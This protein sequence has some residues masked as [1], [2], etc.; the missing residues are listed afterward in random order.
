[1]NQPNF[2]LTV[3]EAIEQVPE[4]RRLYEQDERYSQLLDYAIALEGLSRHTGV[5]AAGVVIAPGPVSDYVPVCTQTSKGSGSA[6]DE[7][8]VVSQYDMNCL[9]KAGMLKMDFLG[10]TTL[11]VIHDALTMIAERRGESID[12][13]AI[14]L[15]DPEVYRMLRAGRTVGV[16]QFESPLAT[17]MLRG[18]RCDRF[19]DL[20]ASNALMRPGPLDAG[21]H[22]VYQ[23]RKKGEEPVA[24]AL[25]EL[26]AIL[27]PTYGVITYQEQ[28]MRIAQQLAGISL[29]EADV[30]RKAVGKKDAELIRQELDKFIEKSVARGYDRKVIRELA[31]QIET[32]GRYGFNKSHSVAYSIISYHT[33]WLKAHFA[34]EFMAALLSSSIGD[35]DN[36]VKYIA[37]A[38]ELGLEVLAPDVNES[39]YKFTVV[40][41][42]RLRFGLGA[43]RNVGHS[44]IDSILAARGERPFTDL[45]DLCERVDLRLCNRR[46]FEALITSGALDSFGVERSRMWAALDSA[47]QEA[48][49]RQAEKESGQASLFG[50]MTVQTPQAESTGTVHQPRYPNVPAWSESER[51]SKEKEILGFYISG[52]PLE[53]YRL[54]CELFATHTVSQLGTWTADPVALGVVITAVKR[55]ISKRSGSEFAR[56]TVEDFSGSAEV[57]IFPE[58]WAAIAD[59]VRTDIPVL[60]RGG[61]SRRDRDVEAP[62][63]IV[64]SVTRFADMKFSG[65]IGVSITLGDSR[66]VDAE[67]LRDVRAVIETHSTGST[68]APALEVRWRDGNG[69]TKLRSRSLRLPAS[70]AALTELRALLGSER[71]HLVRAGQGP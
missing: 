67:V 11:T 54:E 31:E 44:A 21:M 24:Y 66:D 39:G 41:D 2:S 35:T 64:E 25:P 36:V 22:R 57:L 37:E 27:E 42:R 55:Q 33:A 50:D 13:D 8:V 26:Q 58:K 47:L 56:L 48:S 4:V 30:L 1:P 61:Y 6:E 62:T 51:L 12:L 60:L 71:V 15:E 19:D 70:H 5:H 69:G 3:R 53:P 14:P 23:R 9:E 28:V 52:H 18:M 29:A 46:V 34:P 17:D 38:K 43:I 16:F 49:L 32:F 45:F 10:L 59:Q 63:F 7:Q 68:V 40:G 20:V 65:D